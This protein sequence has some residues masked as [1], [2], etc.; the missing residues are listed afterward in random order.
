MDSGFLKRQKNIAM[1]SLGVLSVFTGIGLAFEN[2]GKTV[3]EQVKF[4]RCTGFVTVEVSIF[5]NYQPTAYLNIFKGR[6]NN[7]FYSTGNVKGKHYVSGDIRKITKQC[8]FKSI[9]LI[10]DTP[11]DKGFFKEVR[12]ALVFDA[13]R[14]S[15]K[16][17]RVT[18]AIDSAGKSNRTPTVRATVQNLN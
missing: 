5:D 2:P 4:G 18:L 9:E 8:G 3:T 13:I 14:R 11:A 17:E 15:G 1:L 16:R 6:E 7:I 10:E 12:I